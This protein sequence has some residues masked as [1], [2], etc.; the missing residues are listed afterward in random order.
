MASLHEKP[1]SEESEDGFSKSRQMLLKP[2]LSR[3]HWTASAYI[4]CSVSQELMS[5]SN[6][7]NVCETEGNHLS[8]LGLITVCGAA[9]S[10]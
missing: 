5:P 2:R 9:L 1:S 10:V 8:L 7:I 6:D 4:A 3:Y